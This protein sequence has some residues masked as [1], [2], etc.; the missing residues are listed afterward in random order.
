MTSPVLI[1]EPKVLIPDWCLA[2]ATIRGEAESE[3]FNGKVAVGFVIRER[4]RLKFYSKGDVAST[5]LFPFQFSFW[6]TDSKRRDDICSS[7]LEDPQTK[8]ALQAW[9]A[10]SSTDVLPPGTVLYHADYVMP[11]WAAESVRVAQI[12]RH[13]F[14]KRG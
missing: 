4:M 3:S 8:E 5:V 11:N 13:L 7:L 6:N 10:S 2:V 12:G 14:Y 1:V 9:I